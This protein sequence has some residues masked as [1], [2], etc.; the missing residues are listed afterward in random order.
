MTAATP[1]C[2][3]SLA[4]GEMAQKDCNEYDESSMLNVGIFLAV[5]VGALVLLQFGVSATRRDRGLVRRRLA[6]EFAAAQ[7][8]ATSGLYKNLGTLDIDSWSG[9]QADAVVKPAAQPV[10][11]VWQRFGAFVRQSGLPT[12]PRQVLS[13]TAVAAAI[14]SAVGG[15]LGDG[16]GAV[17]GAAVGG[18][19]PFLA[20]SSMRNRRR[21]R[22]IVQLSSA[23]DQMARVLRAG[24]SVTEA[25]RS[26]VET[27]GSPLSEEFA[28]CLHQIELGIRP[29]EAFQELG[30]GSSVLELRLFVMAMAI[31][32][33]TGGNLAEV[34]DRLATMTRTRVRLRQK[35][36]ALTAEGRL[37]SVTLVVLPPL[38]FA[39]MF[40][41][42]RPYAEA[43]LTHGR[44]LVATAA[45]MA[46]GVLWTRKIIN[47]EG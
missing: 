2:A 40:V 32:R 14:L 25:L 35:I 19:V 34:L 46:V 43:L 6:Q 8:S 26:V 12:T 28:G 45:L 18:V 16:I 47:F 23:F 17:A 42:N 37:Q 20:I 3:I 38:T 1:T 9:E 30:R 24:Q 13:G 41:L 33:Q 7:A 21:E 5:T 11:S 29:E 44:L 4:T 22:L 10:V 15:W 31:H 39:V 27:S 36:N